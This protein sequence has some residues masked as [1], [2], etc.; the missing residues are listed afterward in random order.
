MSIDDLNLPKFSKTLTSSPN[1][2]D[3]SLRFFFV[4]MDT[5][6]RISM[7][8]VNPRSNL[9]FAGQEPVIMVCISC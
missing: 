2:I 8:L 4:G 9:L 7:A 5:A 6:K 3:D 1:G